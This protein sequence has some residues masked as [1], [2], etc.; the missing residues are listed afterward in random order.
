VHPKAEKHFFVC[1]SKFMGR[2]RYVQM[3]Q[4]VV[5][6][7]LL[8]ILSLICSGENRLHKIVIETATSSNYFSL[9]LHNT[10]SKL[11]SMTRIGEI[12]QFGE[13]VTQS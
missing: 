1:F 4:G 5:Q 10:L 7:A 12:S 6:R 8:E 2:S 11:H 3:Y 13:N 9:R